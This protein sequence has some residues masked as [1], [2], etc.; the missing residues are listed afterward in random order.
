ML[1]N[2]VPVSVASTALSEEAT[3]VSVL[4]SPSPAPLAPQGLI[5]CT[6]CQLIFTERWVTG[7]DAERAGGCEVGGCNYAGA[8]FCLHKNILSN[9]Q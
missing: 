5:K 8:I 2:V 9:Q 4:W 3:P 6:D 7:Q 1:Q